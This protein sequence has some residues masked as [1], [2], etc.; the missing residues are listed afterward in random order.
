MFARL[1]DTFLDLHVENRAVDYGMQS[2]K[3]TALI[4]TCQISS[5]IIASNKEINTI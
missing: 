4:L 5:I 2:I 1:F 3:S